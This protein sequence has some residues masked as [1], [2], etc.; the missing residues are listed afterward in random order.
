ML[1]VF[2]KRTFSFKESVFV[3]EHWNEIR[4]EVVPR[5]SYLQYMLSA[6]VEKLKLKKPYVWDR[7]RQ[8][9]GYP[10]GMR[11]HNLNP[12]QNHHYSSP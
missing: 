9:T 6:L 12:F 1:Y 10:L 2:F 5:I 8:P 11:P 3:L 7:P 4:T